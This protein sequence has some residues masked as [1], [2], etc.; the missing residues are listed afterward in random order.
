MLVSKPL[1]QLLLGDAVHY[2]LLCLALL[3]FFFDLVGRAAGAILLIERKSIYF[4]LIGL[5][6]L[7]IGLSLN[8]YL[9]IILRMGLM[10]Y[11]LSALA[12]AVV[13]SLIFCGIAIRKC[14]LSFEPRIARKLIKFQLPL[15]PSSIIS[16]V[17]RQAERILLRFMVSIESVGVLSMGY[18]FPVMLNLFIHE[19]FMKSWNTERIAI[20]DDS[21]GPRRISGMYTYLL[22][23]MTFAGLV[24]AVT[25]EDILAILTPPEFWPAS[26]IA[27][28][29]I[30]TV[31]L[32]SSSFHLNFGLL[33][34]KDTKTWAIIRSSVAILKIGLSYLFIRLWGL[35]GAAYSACAVAA[36][37]ML[38]GLQAGQARYRLWLEYR[39]IL[40]IILAAAAIFLWLTNVDFGETRLARSWAND[41]VP[42][43]AGW[44]EGTALGQW[45]EGKAV[46]ILRDRA[47]LVLDMLIKLVLSCSYLI[48]LPAVHNGTRQRLRKLAV[49][50]RLLR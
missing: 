37:T 11:Y 12:G 49:R 28:I 42:T 33:Y 35:Y 41:V 38:W 34:A 32:T 15:V 4:S 50:L 14:G 47:D 24:L 8:I 30:I 19:P 16:T 29:E 6:H 9:I 13:P 31:I 10:G 7:I 23:L 40:L 25:I 44:L 2:K 39:K 48:L 5:L 22:Y 27:Q 3:A 26:R 46:D 45:K 17:S 18:K 36:I 20:A 1:S 21:D 43:L